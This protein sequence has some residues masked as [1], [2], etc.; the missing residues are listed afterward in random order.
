MPDRPVL[1]YVSNAPAHEDDRAGADWRLALAAL[2]WI[3]GHGHCG[4][5][6]PGPDLDGTVV[7]CPCGDSRLVFEIGDPVLPETEAAA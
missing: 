4:G 3:E 1:L 2:S 6:T 7:A 5:L